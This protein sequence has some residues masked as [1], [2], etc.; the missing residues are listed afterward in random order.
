MPPVRI[1]ERLGSDYVLPDY[2]VKKELRIFLL[3]AFLF[4]HERW[5]TI[6]FLDPGRLSTVLTNCR[7]VKP[8]S[9]I[10]VSAPLGI[11]CFLEDVMLL[12][13]GGVKKA[14]FNAGINQRP[15]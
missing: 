1:E 7:Q 13:L 15:K 9:S 12:P 11:Q 8:Y 3:T 10:I 2:N 4:S 6:C 14:D 5:R